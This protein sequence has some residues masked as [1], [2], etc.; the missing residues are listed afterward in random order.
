VHPSLPESEAKY[1]PTPAMSKATQPLSPSTLESIPVQI[2]EVIIENLDFP[3]LPALHCTT[4]IFSGPQE[5]RMSFPDN[6][7]RTLLRS[8]NSKDT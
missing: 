8:S 1:K 3:T 7:Q 2:L 5:D 6:D 4:E